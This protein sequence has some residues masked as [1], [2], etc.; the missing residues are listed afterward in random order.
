[1][2]F[3]MTNELFINIYSRVQT[4]HFCSCA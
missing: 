3:A 1:M 4:S 2:L